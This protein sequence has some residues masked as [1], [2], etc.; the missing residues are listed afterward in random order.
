LL[1]EITVRRLYRDLARLIRPGGV[2]GHA[3]VMPLAELPVLGVGLTRLHRERSAAQ[4]PDGM[5]DWNAWWEGAAQEPALRRASE[6]RRVIFPTNYPTKEFSPPAE[7]HIAA[8]HD[9]G[10]AEAGVVWRSGTGAVVAA[11]R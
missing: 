3:E 10:F 7:W 2:L 4:V 11:A 8:L 1:S 5:S 6:E 9:A